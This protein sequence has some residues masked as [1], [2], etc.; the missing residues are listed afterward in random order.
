MAEIEKGLRSR[1]AGIDGWLAEIG[2]SCKTDQR[3]C[4]EGTVER[5]Y[6]H[7]GYAVAIKDVLDLL[8]SAAMPIN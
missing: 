6:W 7:Y 4:E 2:S 3:H 1:V 5:A 8:Q